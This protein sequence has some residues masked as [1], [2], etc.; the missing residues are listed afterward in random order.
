MVL[1]KQRISII[2]ILLLFSLVFATLVEAAELTVFDRLKL[3]TTERVEELQQREWWIK[4]AAVSA[5]GFV[6]GKAGGAIGAAAGYIIGAGIG[7]PVVAGMGAMI[8]YRIGDLLTKTFAKAIG[9]IVASRKLDH[10]EP[11]TVSSVLDA[12]K[13]VDKK[14]LTAESAG[15]IL[16]DFIGGSLG[17]AAGVAIFAGMGPLAFPILGTISAALIGQKIGRWAGRALGRAI[18]KKVFKKGYEAYAASALSK[19]DEEGLYKTPEAPFAASQ[20]VKVDESQTRAPPADEHVRQSYQAYV[21]AYK[22]YTDAVT[23][24]A[25]SSVV[26]QRLQKYNKAQQAY[27]NLINQATSK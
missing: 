18:G 9:E 8:G 27:K 2:S 17:V 10:G 26:E 20:T 1:T 23:N 7:G 22:A 25:D 3:K 16:G 19:D 14:S 21:E 6:A 24:N 11:V 4:K 13:L 5:A 15:N 12:V